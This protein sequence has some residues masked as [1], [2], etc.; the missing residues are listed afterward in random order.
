MT[1]GRGHVVIEMGNFFFK[2]PSQFL[3]ILALGLAV[4]GA[5]IGQRVKA[6]LFADGNDFRFPV[7]SRGL[8]TVMPLRERWVTGR[9]VLFCPDWKRFSIKVSTAS[10][11]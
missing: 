9:K 5:G 8:M 4:I 10:S 11:L 6:N 1:Q 2:T 7:K 3:H